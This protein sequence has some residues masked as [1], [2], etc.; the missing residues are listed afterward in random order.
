HALVDPVPEL[1]GGRRLARR[2]PDGRDRRFT[3]AVVGDAEDRDIEHR[4][5][6]NG[7]LLDVPRVHVDPARD[8]QVFLSV[9]EMQEA[10]AV[11]E[12]DVAAVQPAVAEDLRGQI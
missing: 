1:V 2:E 6:P 7:Y 8:D 12:A 11:E 3:P 10:V 5:M 4:R 9:D